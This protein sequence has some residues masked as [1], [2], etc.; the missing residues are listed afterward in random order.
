MKITRA[1]SKTIQVRPYEPV[2]VFCSVEF[3][4]TEAKKELV[5]A[6]LDKFVQ[7]EVMKSIAVFGKDVVDTKKSK[8]V[9]KDCAE[10]SIAELL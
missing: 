9:G 10:T 4:C 1:F 3:E 5:S 2:N 6:Q 7:K 8:D